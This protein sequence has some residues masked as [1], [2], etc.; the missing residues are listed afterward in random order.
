MYLI[1]YNKRDV[2]QIKIKIKIK[3][4]YYLQFCKK[5]KRIVKD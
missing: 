3:I 2:K 4:K 5:N 1:I